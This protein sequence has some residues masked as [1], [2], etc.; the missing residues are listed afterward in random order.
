[1]RM[2]IPMQSL[3][4]MSAFLKFQRPNGSHSWKIRNLL[5]PIYK[6]KCNSKPSTLVSSQ[7]LL[8]GQPCFS[9]INS[10]CVPDLPYKNQRSPHIGT[11][12]SKGI[13]IFQFSSKNVN[14]FFRLIDLFICTPGF[15]CCKA[16]SCLYKRK[17]VLT[18]RR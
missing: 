16:S 8:S 18:K 14:R 2:L 11:R 17:T 7:G 1:M 4:L 10:G 6:D 9:R 5:L 12:K 3:I 15:I 13:I